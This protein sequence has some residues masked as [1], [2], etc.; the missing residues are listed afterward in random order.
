MASRFLKFQ[1]LHLFYLFIYF[2]SA[3]SEV[4]KLCGNDLLL[5]SFRSPSP[6]N[7]DWNLALYLYI[8]QEEAFDFCFG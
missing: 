7:D 2:V 6:R 4:K 1:F 5:C 8:H 3:H